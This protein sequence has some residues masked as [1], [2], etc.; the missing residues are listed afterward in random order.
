MV[1][2]LLSKKIGDVGN[3]H[4]FMVPKALVSA[5]VI[6]KNKEYDILILP[7]GQADKAKEIMEKENAQSVFLTRDLV[8]S[9]K[10]PRF[11]L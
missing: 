1:I 6:E 11:S 3:G 2:K 4:Y 8:Y 10:F 7:K 9:E 5:G